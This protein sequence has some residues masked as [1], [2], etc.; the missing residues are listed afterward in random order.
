MPRPRHLAAGVLARRPDLP[1][2]GRGRDHPLGRRHR[3][4]AG[5]PLVAPGR[6]GRDRWR[7][8][9]RRPDLRRPRLP[10]SRTP[11][12]R[13]DRHQDRAVE[14]LD[15]ES[16]SYHD[17]AFDEEG[18]T[19][20]AYRIDEGVTEIAT[21]DASTGQPIS[22][23]A[24]K[25]PSQNNRATISRDG[26]LLA[27]IGDP[28]DAIQL[29]DMEA[30]RSLGPDP[31]PDRPGSRPMASEAWPSPP[32]AGFWRP[33]GPTGEST[34]GTSPHASSSRPCRPL[35]TAISTRKCG[36]PPTAGPS[37]RSLSSRG[38]RGRRLAG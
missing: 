2:L 24:I 14:G 10:Q 4:Q 32:T 8:L 5:G 35:R 12:D 7:V 20:R 11:H 16:H 19:I 15:P 29:W 21:W 13:V 23:R 38:R 34:S 17:L 6:P 36:S 25:V 1:H 28:F 26:R 27:F 33:G 31:A 18:R 22:T 3:P 9:A 37:P 30:D